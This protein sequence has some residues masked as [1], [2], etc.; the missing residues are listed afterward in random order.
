MRFEIDLDFERL[1][2]APEE[3][4]PEALAEGMEH[5]RGVA[6][7]RTP[8]ETGRLV[9]SATVHVQGDEASLS[10]EGPYARYQEFRLDLH[11]EHG[12]ALYLTSAVREEAHTAVEI[13][14]KRIRDAL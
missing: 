3:I 4:A 12:Q 1:K 8:V 5:I 9:G 13:V 10:Y 6:V 11:H 2:T 7:E 14:T